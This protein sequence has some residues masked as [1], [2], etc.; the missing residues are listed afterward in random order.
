MTLKNVQ[1]LSIQRM[2]RE[3]RKRRKMGKVNKLILQ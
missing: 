1:E 3:A 2:N